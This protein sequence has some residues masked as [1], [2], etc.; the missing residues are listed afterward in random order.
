M[1]HPKDHSHDLKLSDSDN[2]D[3]ITCSI[4]EQE[5]SPGPTSSYACTKTNCEFIL[6]ESCF[7]LPMKLRHK[8][9]REHV[10]TLTSELIPRPYTLS[11][12]CDACGDLINAFV[13]QCNECDYKIH[14]ACALLPETVRCKG[15]VHSLDLYYSTLELGSLS[16]C[17][18]CD[19]DL[20]EGFWNY[21]CKDCGFGTHLDCVTSEEEE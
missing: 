12:S 2:S 21:Y 8:S 7:Q 15:H 11:R 13:Y 4:C 17:D 10:F 16:C 18:V 1:N 6:H 9:H 5:L 3:E 14:V 20:K 19:G